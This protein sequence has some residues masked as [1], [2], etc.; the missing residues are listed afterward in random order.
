MHQRFVFAVAAALGVGGCAVGYGV[1][2]QSATFSSKAEN[3][4]KP[5]S[6]HMSTAY[7]ELRIIDSTGLLLAAFVNA[8]R[9]Y[10]AR[11]DAIEAARYKAPDANG[12][13][14]VEYSYEPMPILAG[15]L[16]DFRLRL[17]LGT[18]TLEDPM[19]T[20]EGSNLSFWGFDLRPE[21][22]TFRPIKSLPMV[23]SLWLNVE[24][25]SYEAE[26]G[27]FH[28][29]TIDMGFGASTS[30]VIREDLM[31]TARAKIG[32]LSPLFALLAGGPKLNPSAELEVGYRP[33]SSSKVGLMLSANAAIGRD[34]EADG[35][36]V[37][38]PRVGLGATVTFGNQVPKKARRP[39]PEPA[40][41]PT[42]GNPQT[43]TMSGVVC[44]GNDAPAECKQVIDALPD[45][46]KVLFIA[47]GQATVNAANATPIDFSTQPGVCRTAGVGLTNYLT[48]NEA[49]LDDQTKRMLRIGA[50]TAFDLAAVGYE[51]S[52]GKQSADHCAMIEATFTA[53][54]GPDSAN[55]VLPTRV[56][57]T[58]A[59]V[60]Q[61]RPKYTC[62]ADETQG[63]VCTPTTTGQ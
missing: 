51:V 22:Y 13:V 20:S 35:G 38:I 41:T 49:T 55:P 27:D 46:P 14:H 12:M 25:A 60:Q 18:P 47:C 57:V 39:D 32:L 15:L 17:P 56:Q 8:G 24:T 3:G 21:F 42:T 16:T 40:P 6:Q 2:Y 43:G 23:S 11:A 5:P 37:V 28:A 61:C 29:F 58:N 9:Q 52:Q 45:A 54:V 36:G 1:G 10:N 26:V 59:N 34:F 19:G 33:W 30:Y 31:A 63:V 62:H 44:L 50:A 48:Q 53:V 7:Q 4:V